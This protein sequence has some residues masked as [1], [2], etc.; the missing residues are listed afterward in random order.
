MSQKFTELSASTI[1]DEIMRT[2]GVKFGYDPIFK[3]NGQESIDHAGDEDPLPSILLDL[4]EEKSIVINALKAAEVICKRKLESKE[5][6]E[7][8]SAALPFNK[9]YSEYC[10]KG[11]MF[12]DPEL[13][14][15]IASMR[16]PSSIQEAIAI[17][18]STAPLFINVFIDINYNLL[19]SYYETQITEAKTVE[20]LNVLS[21]FFALVASFMIAKGTIYIAKKSSNYEQLYSFIK[22]AQILTQVEFLLR[23]VDA[24]HSKFVAKRIGL[25]NIRKRYDE[26]LERY[27]N[28]LEE[29]KETAEKMWANDD[30]SDHVEM[31]E[32]IKG[33]DKFSNIPATKLKQVINPIAEK[34]NRKKG[35]LGYK[36][37]K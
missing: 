26:D 28:L 1:L 23:L 36:K 29:V 22:I 32:Y 14:K 18:E 5:F 13:L 37:I 7:I 11:V 2:L 31:L 12:S 9:K 25:K 10:D 19:E 3:M 16:F 8:W 15:Q 34:Y 6:N 24:E 17:S 21:L 27:G 33:K 30:P 4:H 35:V 20:N